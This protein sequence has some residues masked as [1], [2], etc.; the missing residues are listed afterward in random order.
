MRRRQDAD[1]DDLSESVA[2]LGNVGLTI[3]EELDA[4]ARVAARLPCCRRR[5]A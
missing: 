3:G 2:R 5:E 4:Q 1:L